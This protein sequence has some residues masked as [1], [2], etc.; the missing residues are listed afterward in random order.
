MEITKKEWRALGIAVLLTA[1]ITALALMSG[2]AS[3]Q[4]ASMAGKTQIEFVAYAK[5]ANAK[6]KQAEDARL[7][8][9]LLDLQNK[10]E[11]T[12]AKPAAIISHTLQLVANR[13]A[14]LAEW[15]K[16]NV[17]ATNILTELGGINAYN[18]NGVTLQQALD[19]F[20][21]LIASAVTAHT[22]KGAP[23]NAN[24]TID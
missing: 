19:I 15:G 22:T 18:K 21:P 1:M 10:A 2:C 7:E 11:I 9:E 3:R 20:T 4:A 12:G 14:R 17:M 5:A 8:L 16:T 24:V 23:T 6:A 13:D